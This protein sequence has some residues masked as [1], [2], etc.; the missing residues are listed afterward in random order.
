MGDSLFLEMKNGSK[1]VF[2]KC[3]D[4]RKDSIPLTEG[5]G[6]RPGEPLYYDDEEEQGYGIETN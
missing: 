1:V 4:L 6:K 3:G 5:M 2:V